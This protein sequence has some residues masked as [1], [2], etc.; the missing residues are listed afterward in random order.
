MKQVQQAPI[1]SCPHRVVAPGGLTGV[2]R[3][4]RTWGIAALLQ[5]GEPQKR[6]G[7]RSPVLKTLRTQSEIMPS[8]A[9]QA[10]KSAAGHLWACLGHPLAF[11][12]LSGLQFALDPSLHGP[13][14][15]AMSKTRFH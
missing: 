1:L 6:A 10:P 13:Y 12:W 2:H 4:M 14:M 7:C 5:P 8:A 9:P 3:L 11:L 15:T